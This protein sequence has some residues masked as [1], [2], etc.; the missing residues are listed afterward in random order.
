MNT[1][2]EKQAYW[3]IHDAYWHLKDFLTVNFDKLDAVSLNNMIANCEAL[4]DILAHHAS[5]SIW[6]VDN[7]LTRKQQMINNKFN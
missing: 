4:Q 5:Y 2:I 7:D 1:S 3:I 6:L